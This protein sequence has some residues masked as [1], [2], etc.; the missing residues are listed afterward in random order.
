MHDARSLLYIISMVLVDHIAVGEMWY[1]LRP[2]SPHNVYSSKSKKDNK[3]IKLKRDLFY[4]FSSVSC[5]CLSN[6]SIRRLRQHYS[7]VFLSIRLV[8]NY[9]GIRSC[10]QNFLILIHTETIYIGTCR[11]G[12]RN[13]EPYGILLF[14]TTPV[15]LHLFTYINC[16]HTWMTLENLLSIH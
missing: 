16:T 7:T 9:V 5:L 1:K 3:A 15:H 12:R 14:G 11:I 2:S 10:L 8:C 13:Q 6:W 4:Y